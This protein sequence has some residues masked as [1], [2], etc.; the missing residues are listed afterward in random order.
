MRASEAFLLHRALPSGPCLPGLCGPVWGWDPGHRT[1]TMLPSQCWNSCSLNSR[2]CSASWTMS[3]SVTQPWRRRWPWPPSCRACSPSQV[4]H[5][6]SAQSSS[7]SL[8]H[9]PEPARRG[10]RAWHSGLLMA[11]PMSPSP[12]ALPHHNPNCS[13]C[14]P[15]STTHYGLTHNTHAAHIHI[16]SRMQ[17]TLTTHRLSTSITNTPTYGTQ[18]NTRYALTNSTCLGT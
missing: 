11:W 16:H 10:L 4:S 6:C 5:P 1:M 7:E 13:L 15:P 2:G 9:S 3:T 12:L 17:H 14:T 18:A 8:S